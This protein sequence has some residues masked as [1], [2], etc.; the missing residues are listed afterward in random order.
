MYSRAE[1]VCPYT[2]PQ[3]VMPSW[4]PISSM[5]DWGTAISGVKSRTL[6]WNFPALATMK[7]LAVKLD[8][9]L[10]MSKPLVK[11]TVTVSSTTARDREVIVTAVLPRLRPRLAQ[12]MASREDPPA[13]L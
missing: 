13:P 8:T 4:A 6:F 3:S 11:F 5:A 10:S 12:A 2:T 1:E 9:Y 7:S